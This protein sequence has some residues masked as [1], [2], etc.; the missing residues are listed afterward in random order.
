MFVIG[1]LVSFEDS[2]KDTFLEG[3]INESMAERP[4][5][6]TF[7]CIRVLKKDEAVTTRASQSSSSLV[8][9]NRLLKIHRRA[10]HPRE[11]KAISQDHL[12]HIS[13]FGCKR[14][15]PQSGGVK[16]GLLPRSREAGRVYIFGDFKDSVAHGALLV[17]RGAVYDVPLEGCPWED[18]L[19]LVLAEAEGSR[20]LLAQGF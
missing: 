2:S 5:E 7:L 9:H 8:L 20:D 15:G 11:D 18:I 12:K 1:I 14:A 17:V 19:D 6:L 16:H 4:D 13:R 10:R 3:T